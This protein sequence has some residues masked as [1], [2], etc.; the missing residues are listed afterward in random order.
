MQA[1]A[2]GIGETLPASSYRPAIATWRHELATV[3]ASNVV[4]FLAVHIAVALA[5]IILLALMS[6]DGWPTGDFLI[7]WLTQLLAE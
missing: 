7:H 4:L 5:G 1:I 2:L 6:V 3:L